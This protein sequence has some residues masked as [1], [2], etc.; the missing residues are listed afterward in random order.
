MT[1]YAQMTKAQIEH[2]REWHRRWHQE[3]P[4]A[5][6]EIVRRFKAN[7]ENRA[8]Y[9]GQQRTR[10]AEWRVVIDLYKM[11]IGCVDCGEHF[12][13]H[14]ECLAFDHLPGTDKHHVLSRMEGYALTAIIAKIEKCEVVCHNCHATRT[15]DRRPTNQPTNPPKEQK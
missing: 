4:Q 10:Y 15:K 6:R 5:S 14:P 12:E 9:N 11:I 8:R 1:I 7:P 2:S 13:V 3:H